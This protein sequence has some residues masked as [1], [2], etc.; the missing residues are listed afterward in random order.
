MAKLF[1]NVQELEDIESGDKSKMNAPR[2]EL[3]LLMLKF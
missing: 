2:Y 3:D 1:G